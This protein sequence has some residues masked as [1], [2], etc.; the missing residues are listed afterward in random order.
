MKRLILSL[1]ILISAIAPKAALAQGSPCLNDLTPPTVTW[2]VGDI[3]KTAANPV[4]IK[5][6]P[7]GYAAI[8]ADSGNGTAGINKAKVAV[9]AQFTQ[10]G[11]ALFTIVNAEDA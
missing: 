8:V 7:V 4:I 6:S 2:N 9:P 10:S 3:G 11:A 5:L 1:G